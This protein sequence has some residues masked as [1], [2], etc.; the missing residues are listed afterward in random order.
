MNVSTFIGA[1][2]SLSGLTP[3]MVLH[4]TGLAEKMSDSERGDVAAHMAAG[5]EVAV[6][7]ANN[8]V[9]VIE[10]GL[11]GIVRL[12]KQLPALRGAHEAAEQDKGIADAES[13][14]DTLA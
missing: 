8:M 3:A 5:S 14:L 11:D 7:K 10:E 6:Q 2:Q 13:S 9:R 12:Q 1:I 4:L